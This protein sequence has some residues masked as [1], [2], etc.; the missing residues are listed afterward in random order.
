VRASYKNLVTLTLALALPAAVFSAPAGVRVAPEAPGLM[1]PVSVSQER[2]TAFQEGEDLKFVVKWGVVTGGYSSLKVQNT[3]TVEGEPTYHIVAEAHSTGLVNSMYHVNDRNEAWVQPQTRNTL[4]Y[5]RKIQEGKYRL[6]EQVVL[7]QKDHRYHLSSY[8]QDKNRHKSQEGDIPANVL[9]VLGSFYYVRTL[10]LAVGK[11]FTIDVHSGDQV[12]P[13]LV[14]VKKRQTVKVQAGKFDC[15]LVEPELRAP[16]IF[17]AKGKK[18]E[19]FLT[20]DERRM[21]VLMRSEIFIGHVRAELVSHRTV[22]PTETYG[23]AQ[24]D[25]A[26]SDPTEADQ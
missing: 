3:E 6:D 12:Y 9:D 20:A 16:G 22:T 18:L 26:D 1:P 8:R 10:P 13:L 2:P 21:P 4:K 17:V 23:I 7:D 15:F 5:S 24:A 25:K 19:V 14:T 11:T